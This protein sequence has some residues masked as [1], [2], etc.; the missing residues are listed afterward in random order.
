MLQRAFELHLYIEVYKLLKS[1]QE[2]RDDPELDNNQSE[3]NSDDQGWSEELPQVGMSH[4]SRGLH[5][6]ERLQN[7]FRIQVRKFSRVKKFSIIMFILGI[8]L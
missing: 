3:L 6:D 8:N 2:L 5:S 1:E 7:H 4:R